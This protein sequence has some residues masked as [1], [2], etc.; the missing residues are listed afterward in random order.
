[1]H[2]SIEENLPGFMF[3]AAF[4]ESLPK[5]YEPVE[6]TADEA[7]EYRR[8]IAQI[9]GTQ[10]DYV[11][12]MVAERI[13]RGRL[14]EVRRFDGGSVLVRFDTVIKDANNREL[15]DL[16]LLLHLGADGRLIS[17]TN[18][19]PEMKPVAT[20][21]IMGSGVSRVC[22][23]QSPSDVLAILSKVVAGKEV[24]I[25]PNGR[26]GYRSLRLCPEVGTDGATYTARYFF[27]HPPVAFQKSGLTYEEIGRL[28]SGFMKNGFS[29]LVGAV[30]WE[31]WDGCTEPNHERRM[32]IYLRLLFRRF[33]AEFFGRSD[34]VAL[35][36]RLGVEDVPTAAL[37]M[38]CLNVAWPEQ[39][40]Y[41]VRIA[42]G[43]EELRTDYYKRPLT[44]LDCDRVV[45]YAALGGCPE[46]K[47]DIAS[48]FHI[49]V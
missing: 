2:R 6:P 8:A 15:C 3:P 40:S 37:W 31:W 21:A 20:Y 9:D 17:Y 33:L 46:A 49:K 28:V 13:R 26:T 10:R 1:M 43:P 12:G 30:E 24:L 47:A 11:E 7:V 32:G 5:D 45:A 14:R 34:E 35:L 22:S 41:L 42:R 23:L 48:K 44:P 16:Q 29:W 38:R 18:T 25:A 36:D 19:F 4:L 27:S 39:L